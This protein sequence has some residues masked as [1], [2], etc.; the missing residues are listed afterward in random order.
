MTAAQCIVDMTTCK[1][2]TVTCPNCV[3]V[4]EIF[5]GLFNNSRLTE[6]EVTRRRVVIKKK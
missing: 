1:Q 5:A 6:D 2:K 4:D 3:R